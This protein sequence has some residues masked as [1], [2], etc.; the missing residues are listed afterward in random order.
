MGKA[1]LGTVGKQGDIRIT[2]SKRNDKFG[3]RGIRRRRRR[4]NK[5][6]IR[7]N[8]FNKSHMPRNIYFLSNG[9]ETSIAFGCITIA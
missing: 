1:T 7:K 5:I 8:M 9:I 4:N 3:L 2:I 6:R